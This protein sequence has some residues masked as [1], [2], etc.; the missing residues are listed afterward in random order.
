MSCLKKRGGDGKS[1]W[2][3]AVGGGYVEVLEKLWDWAK[4]LQLKADE[5]RSE[6]L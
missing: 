2:N 5:L 6:V 1:V 3:F 4:E